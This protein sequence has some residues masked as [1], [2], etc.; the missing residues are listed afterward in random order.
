MPLNSY[1]WTH[2]EAV[3]SPEQYKTLLDWVQTIKID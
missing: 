3:V 2:K 1:L